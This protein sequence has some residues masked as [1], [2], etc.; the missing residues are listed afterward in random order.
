[1]LNTAVS[2]DCS[3]PAIAVDVQAAAR[4][5]PLAFE[6]WDGVFNAVADHP[7]NVVQLHMA[8]LDAPPQNDEKQVHLA[9]PSIQN[10]NQQC[11]AD[12]R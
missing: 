6:L 12:Q 4:T 7:A 3:D 8:A 10:A 2:V 5:K 11:D 9:Q 1:M